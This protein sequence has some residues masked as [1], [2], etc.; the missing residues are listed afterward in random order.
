MT[1]LAPS[2][3]RKVLWDGA[4]PLVNYMGEA[5]FGSATSDPVWRITRLTFSGLDNSDLTLEC[6]DGN[7]EFDNVWDDRLVLTYL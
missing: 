4:D 1:T 2:I 5:S 3:R 7:D 6:A